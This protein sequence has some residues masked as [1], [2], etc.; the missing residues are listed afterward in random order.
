MAGIFTNSVCSLLNT[1]PP[2][3]VVT[4]GGLAAAAGSPRGARQV[5]RI[6]H[7]QSKVRNLP[8][9]R[10]VAAG[11][12]IALNDPMAAGLQKELLR[13]EG[14]QMK[15]DGRVDMKR[16]NWDFTGSFPD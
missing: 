11:G 4:Y 13:S 2:G 7:S 3:F 6:L 12:R 15:N 9:H 16:H 14:V 10:V 8:W 5:V 1:V